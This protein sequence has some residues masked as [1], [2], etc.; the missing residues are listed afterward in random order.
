MAGGGGT[1]DQILFC[2]QVLIIVFLFLIH[3]PTTKSST[4]SIEW[5]EWLNLSH[6]IDIASMFHYYF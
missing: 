4:N 6:N 5:P 3:I 2:Q 1:Q